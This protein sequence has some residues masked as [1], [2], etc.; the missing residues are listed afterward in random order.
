VNGL[1]LAEMEVSEMLDV[2]HYF[3]EED[4]R[5]TSTEQADF[6]DNFRETIYEKLYDVKYE[7]MSKR[8]DE[9]SYK[10]FDDSIEDPLDSLDSEEAEVIEPF[11]P[12]NKQV[13]SF[14]EPSIP[15]ETSSRPFG[16]VLDEP[17]A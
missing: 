8:P 6:K 12:R 1:R 13:K 3:F 17:L 14:I 5:Y 11:S 2:I 15:Q 4:Y 16:M 7:Y 9:T 10:D